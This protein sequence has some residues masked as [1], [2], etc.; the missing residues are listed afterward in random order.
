MHNMK[1]SIIYIKYVYEVSFCERH[2][3]NGSDIVEKKIKI[4]SDH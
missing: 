1:G 4:S 3:Y 2:L